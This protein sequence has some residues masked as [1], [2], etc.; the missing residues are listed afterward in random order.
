MYKPSVLLVV[1]NEN[2]DWLMKSVE[3]IINQTYE[4]YEFIIIND[5]SDKKETIKTLQIISDM[6]HR[7]NVFNKKNDGLTK[8]LNFG[9]EKCNGNII[10]R[11]DSDDWSDKHRIQIQLNYLQENPDC[12]LVGLTPVFC[13]KNGNPLWIKELPLTHQAIVKAFETLNPFC[14]GSVCF[15][16]E[17]VDQL[18]GYDESLPV[19]QDYDLFWRMS[20]LGLSININ[21]PLY[22]LRKTGKSISSDRGLE[23]MFFDEII[24]EKNNI[25]NENKNIISNDKFLLMR[26]NFYKNHNENKHFSLIRNGDELLLS[27]GIL[28]SI[29][30]YFKSFKYGFSKMVIFKI[31]RWVAWVIM[32]WFRHKMF[33]APLERYRFK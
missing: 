9:I 22:F 18:G 7:I 21:E 29:S 24:K 6:D 27:G 30:A 17:S 16:K 8:S 11:Q 26:E 28:K 23:Q 2:P 1:Y 19:C 10:F 14:H 3:S 31:F 5:G 12:I 13:Q 25:T 4:D 15:R 20:N 33:S 32:P